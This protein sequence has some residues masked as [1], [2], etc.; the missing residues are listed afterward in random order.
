M[1]SL[2]TLDPRFSRLAPSNSQLSRTTAVNQ[3]VNS[4]GHTGHRNVYFTVTNSSIKI[5]RDSTLMM[6]LTNGFLKFL[7]WLVCAYPFIWMYR[8][9]GKEGGKRDVCRASYVC[10]RDPRDLPNLMGGVPLGDGDWVKIWERTFHLS[11]GNRIQTSRPI[12]R[13]TTNDSGV[14][15]F[16]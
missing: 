10:N 11:V 12:Y 6:L 14:I 3:I 1:V 7:L 15:A 8:R 4:T 9:Y 2:S 5:Q 13:P 16:D